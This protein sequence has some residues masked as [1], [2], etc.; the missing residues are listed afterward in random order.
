MLEEKNDNLSVQLNETD[1]NVENES[2]EVI[3]PEV[4][5]V[6]EIPTEPIAEFEIEDAEVVIEEVTTET[7]DAITAIENENAAENED[8][9]LKERHEIPMLDYE[10]LSMEEI[11]DELEKLN[12][13][14]NIMSVKDHVE[15][16]KNSF[17]AKYYHFLE[18]KKEEF[19]AETADL[20]FGRFLPWLVA[21]R[22]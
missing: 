19:N 10:S 16:I 3:Q 9:T 4:E 21:W 11:I 2:Q 12:A 22:Q 14:E 6:E 8:E 17:L 7:S 18:E 15:E 13:I 20:L 1:G 5:E